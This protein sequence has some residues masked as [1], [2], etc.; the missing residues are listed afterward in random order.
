MILNNKMRILL[1]PILAV[2]AI[3]AMARPTRNLHG[4]VTDPAGRP[5]KGAAVKLKDTLTL[6]VRSFITQDNGEYHF[7][8]LDPDIE[9]EVIAACQGAFSETKT[10]S[11]FSS[12]R[13]V[14]IH[15]IITP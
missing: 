11:K 1:A 7:Y 2:C 9:Y 15:L 6:T 3:S 12:K 8:R 4:T 13:E 5:I 14:T 10:V